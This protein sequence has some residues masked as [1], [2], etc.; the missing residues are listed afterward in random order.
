M[1]KEE[2]ILSVEVEN[3]NETHQDTISE[4]KSS[5][6]INHGDEIEKG[7]SNAANKIIQQVSKCTRC[8]AVFTKRQNMLNHIKYKHEGVRYPCNQCDYNAKMQ[9]HLKR[10]LKSV[11]EGVKYPCNQCD[12]KA[13]QQIHLKRHLESV[14]VVGGKYPCSQ[15][16]VKA[17][18]ISY[19][20]RHMKRTH[21]L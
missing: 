6:D 11:H 17:T 9:Q 20:K 7:R 19:L 3:V 14:H 13:T 1:L 10:H 21:K 12:Y 4:D 15:C 8:D 18:C 5:N 16:D 2:N